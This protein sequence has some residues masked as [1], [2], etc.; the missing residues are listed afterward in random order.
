MSISRAI[1]EHLTASSGV[2][3]LVSTRIYP[4]MA[5]TSAALPRVIYDLD[6]SEHVHHM[7]GGSGL[8]RRSISL[9]IQ[10]QSSPSADAIAEAI[11]AVLDKY[12]G[13]MGSGAAL[14]VRDCI[15]TNE[16][17]T[18]LPPTNASQFG[19]YLRT[20]DFDVWHTET[21]PVYA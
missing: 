2:T 3:N 14:N 8:V 17:Q 12:R 19:V 6:S 9:E 1:Y 13:T 10:A 11:R 16:N 20:M 4:S 21:V 7:T 15:L 18:F 5:P